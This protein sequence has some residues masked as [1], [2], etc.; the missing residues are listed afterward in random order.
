VAVVSRSKFEL[1]PEALALVEQ[2]RALETRAEAAKQALGVELAGIRE[3]AAEE[4]R[5]VA[6]Q[7]DALVDDRE[8]L[9]TLLESRVRGVGFIA[10][11]WADYERARAQRLGVA[12][13]YKSHPAKSAA[14]EVRAKGAR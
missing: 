6:R 5:E 3:A 2:V 10:D 11:A 7:H 12:L 13:Q 8:A 4:R 9:E 1:P 14:K